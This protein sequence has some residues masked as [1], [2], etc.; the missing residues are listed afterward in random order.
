MT[1]A[2][3]RLPNQTVFPAICVYLC[4]NRSSRTGLGCLTG[5]L[6]LAEQGLNEQAYTAGRVIAVFRD[7]L[8][9]DGLDRWF[10]VYGL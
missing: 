5:T 6:C 9:I 1:W 7:M 8:W 2:D 4:M 10:V 3:F